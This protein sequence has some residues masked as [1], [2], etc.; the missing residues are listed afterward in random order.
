MTLSPQPIREA[1]RREDV[2]HGAYAKHTH[3]HT[4]SHTVPAVVSAWEVHTGSA[5]PFRRSTM[6]RYRSGS[7]SEDGL[8]FFLSFTPETPTDHH[9][10]R[11]VPW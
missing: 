10:A 11:Q 6:S 5:G 1:V 2:M 8:F 7:I 3:T 4:N 9:V